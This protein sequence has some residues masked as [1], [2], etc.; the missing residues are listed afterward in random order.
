MIQTISKE[1]LDL[2]SDLHKNPHYGVASLAYAPIVKQVFK[3]I[4]ALSISDYGAGKCNLKVGLEQQG[5]TGF[6]Y[7][8]YDPVFPG[9]GDPKAA[10]LVCCIDVLEHVEEEFLLNVMEDLVKIT[11]RVGFFTIAT[12]PAQKVLADGRNAH[13]IQKPSSWWLPKFLPYFNIEHLE[14]DEQGFWI[15]VR[16]LSSL[17]NSGRP[18]ENV[19]PRRN[20]TQ[21]KKGIFSAALS[22]IGL[23]WDR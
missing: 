1:Y 20:F 6:D 11:R 5:I 8:P 14:N 12:G 21:E 4:G 3:S 15:I 2:Q 13:L 19:L 16:P 18:F 9:Y 23:I 10:D 7:F 22:Q 17:E